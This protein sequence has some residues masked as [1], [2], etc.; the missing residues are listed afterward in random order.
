MGFLE[1]V[2]ELLDWDERII[3]PEQYELTPEIYAAPPEEVWVVRDP[4]VE[5]DD[6]LELVFT[7]RSCPDLDR[8]GFVF[9]QTMFLVRVGMPVF[10][11]A[12]S[13]ELITGEEYRADKDRWI[14]LDELI[15]VRHRDFPN[16]ARQ[17]TYS[18][19]QKGWKEYELVDV[20][21]IVR[22]EKRE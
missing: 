14:V 16:E 15:V 9:V 20:T 8:L 22:S 17:V 13:G 21:Y 3:Y 10:E 4:R 7:N 2:Q 6:G 5:G 1:R 11:T 18:E 19:Y 12:L